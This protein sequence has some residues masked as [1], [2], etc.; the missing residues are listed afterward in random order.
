[1]ADGAGGLAGW[2]WIFL[3]EGILTAAAAALSWFVIFRFPVEETRYFT[4]EEHAVLLMRLGRTHEDD[5]IMLV[6]A[7][8]QILEALSSWKIWCLSVS[9]RPWRKLH[10]FADH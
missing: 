7:S 1:M 6:P 10:Q 5:A 4:V 8:K 2:R 3:V 9:H